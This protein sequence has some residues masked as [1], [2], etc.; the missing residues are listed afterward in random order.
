MRL[1]PRNPAYLASYLTVLGEAYRLTGR[2]EEAITALK[3]ALT[4]MPN[5][6]GPHQILAI[7]YSEAGREE[8]ARAEAEEILKVSPNFSLE[9]LRQRL[10]YKDPGEVERVLAALRKAGLKGVL[11]YFLEC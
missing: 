10:P 6:P 7:I 4:L 2:N 9:G 5:L 8:E 11:R 3:R 1:N